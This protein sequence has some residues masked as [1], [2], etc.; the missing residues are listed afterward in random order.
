M[1]VILS[2][3]YELLH[4]IMGYITPD[5]SN[6]ILHNDIRDLLSLRW[7]CR[8]FRQC[9]NQLSFWSDDNFYFP[10]L[11]PRIDEDAGDRSY[12][13]NCG[14]H[15]LKFIDCF[16]KDEDLRSSMGR[17]QV[18][19]FNNLS[20][21][22][23]VGRNLPDFRVNIRNMTLDFQCETTMPLFNVNRAVEFLSTCPN[24][25]SLTL[26][27]YRSFPISLDGIRN[28]C[29]SVK[30]LHIVTVGWTTGSLTMMHGLEEFHL[31]IR[32]MPVNQGSQEHILP[33]ESRST[34]LALN[35]EYTGLTSNNIFCYSNALLHFI[36][37]RSLTMNN[38]DN[39][40]F[41]LI[42]QANFLNLEEFTLR[43][44]YLGDLSDESL[45][46]DMFSASCLNKLRSLVLFTGDGWSFDVYR[47]IFFAVADHC[48]SLLEILKLGMG[49]ST[50]WCRL[51]SQFPRLRSLFWTTNGWNACD[52]DDPYASPAI[53]IDT[54]SQ[55]DR[56]ARLWWELSAKNKIEETVGDHLLDV[57]I[58]IDAID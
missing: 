25:S 57:Y 53:N 34:L 13:R 19:C 33:I 16:T 12:L 46:G 52:S 14:I 56:R 24:L 2:L 54:S 50:A 42:V 43:V 26:H 55:D 58:R 38:V 3:P 23:A 15:A 5:V 30:R 31:S 44:P 22:V 47:R 4:Q 49:I 21:L 7:T 51:F 48:S 35:L 32:D 18:W 40:F 39:R 20:H 37:L 41:Q 11:T 17:K 29:L 36:N 1:N 45:F 28:N 10:A 27:N 8:L 6:D 9:V